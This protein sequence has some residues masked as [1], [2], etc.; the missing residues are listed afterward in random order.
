MKLITTLSLLLFSLGAL[1]ADQIVFKNG[2][3]LTGSIV[4]KDG[5]NLVIKGAL[6]GVVT[7]PWDQVESVKSDEALNVV[8]KDKTVKSRIETSAGR[9]ELQDPPQSLA[10]A[11]VVGLRNAAEQ[12]AYERL[13]HP[14]LGQLWAGAASLGFAGTVGNAQ[15]NTLTTAVTAARATRT[16]KTSLYFNTIK[17]SA[18]VGGVKAGTAEAVRGGW[19]YNHNI[20]SHFLINTFN[21]YEYDK[22]Q[23]LDLRFVLGGGFGFIAR[24]TERTR[25][26]VV[27]GAAYERSKFSPIDKPTF[28]RNAASAYWGDDYSLKLTT[29]TSLTQTFRMFNNLS[30]TGEYRVNFDVNANTKLT[31]WLSWTVGLSDRYLSNPVAGR[32]ANDF[33]YTTGLGVSF[34]H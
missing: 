2:D 27:G 26:D 3:R 24:R 15:T 4:K 14:G 32:K 8:L 29:A 22:F 16:D 30:Q 1:Q 12:A 20:S 17:A 23:S 31:K 25:L 5:N 34:A 33:L 6:T 7:V 19:A 10:V 21:D 9:V 13:L 11:D 18:L 28:S